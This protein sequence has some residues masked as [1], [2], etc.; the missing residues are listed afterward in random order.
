MKE[1]PNEVDIIIVG[2]TSRWILLI[3]IGGAAGCVVA[4]RLAKKFRD[5]QFL[6]IEAGGNNRDDPL[7]R[8]PAFYFHHL[9]PDSHTAQFYV[10]KPSPDVAGR[11]NV[12]AA[13][14]VLGGGS[15]INFMMY[16][17]AS[18]SD[19]D[20][21]NTEGWFFKDLKPLLLKVSVQVFS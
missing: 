9:K 7:V 13:G 5:L 8:T 14:G 15:S 17:R 20:D 2:G 18:A 10:S 4:G 19:Y 6:I 12:V 21:W 11:S 3:E 1:A 16:T